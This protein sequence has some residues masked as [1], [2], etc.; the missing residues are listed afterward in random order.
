MKSG[1]LFDLSNSPSYPSPLDRLKTGKQERAAQ[2]GLSDECEESFECNQ[3]FPRAMQ[4]I[5]KLKP[6]SFS[7]DLNRMKGFELNSVSFLKKNLIKNFNTS[8]H[9]KSSHHLFNDTVYHN[10]TG[11]HCLSTTFDKSWAFYNQFVN[12]NALV[13]SNELAEAQNDVIPISNPNKALIVINGRTTEILTA[14]NISCDLFGYNE[15]K[16]IGM[17][18]KDLL[19]LSEKGSSGDKNQEILME[20]DRLDQNGRVVLCSGK[21]FD[22]ITVDPLSG[23]QQAGSKDNYLIIPISMYMLKLT[24]EQEPKCLCVM[25][26]VQ[27]VVGNFAINLKVSFEFFLFICLFNRMMN[28]VFIILRAGLNTTT[29]ILAIY[30]GIRI[31]SRVILLLRVLHLLCRR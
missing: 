6:S 28:F 2:F 27:R 31:R 16:L 29:R 24:D 3:S 26:P 19:D 4:P 5:S 23:H 21:I 9:A 13:N 25:E 22:A 7:P 12:T 17:K 18:L 10:E 15:S 1:R 11:A 20:L 30:S 14:N 8:L